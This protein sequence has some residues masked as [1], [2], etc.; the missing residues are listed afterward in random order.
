M[1]GDGLN[2]AP[3]LAVADIG[4]AIG[5]GVDVT[6][7]TADISLL[8]EDLEQVAWVWQLAQATYRR[9]RWNLVWAFFYNVIGIGLAVTGLLHPI[10]SAVAMVLSNLMV[11]GNSMGLY[12]FGRNREIPVQNTP[13]API[14]DELEIIKI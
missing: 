10:L 1:V 2:D 5:S 3:A 6:R 11:V 13:P 8:G 4:I 14:N 9:I 12:R 7:E